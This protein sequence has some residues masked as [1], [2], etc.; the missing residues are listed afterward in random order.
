M[1]YFFV[2]F[3]ESSGYVRDK[4]VRGEGAHSTNSTARCSA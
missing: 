3:F 4:G 1:M 2:H